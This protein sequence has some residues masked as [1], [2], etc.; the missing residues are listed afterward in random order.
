LSVGREQI[1][2]K[3]QVG[4]NYLIAV[5]MRTL[6]CCGQRRSLGWG[7]IVGYTLQQKGMQMKEEIKGGS[8]R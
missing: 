1:K 7:D 5:D 3:L 8:A 2:D 4:D 6:V